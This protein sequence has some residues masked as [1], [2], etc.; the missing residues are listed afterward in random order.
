LKFGPRAMSYRRITRGT[1]Y[2]TT[3]AD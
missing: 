2:A 1:G 3:L